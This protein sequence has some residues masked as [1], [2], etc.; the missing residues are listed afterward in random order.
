MADGHLAAPSDADISVFTSTDVDH[1]RAVLNRF[2]YPIS[3]GVTGAG[4][5]FELNLKV[6]QLGPLTVGQLRFGAGVS[7]VAP[8]LDAYHVT[9]PRTGSCLTRHA[10][11]EVEANPDRAAVFGP[12]GRVFTL[13]EPLSSELDLKIAQ[14]ELEHELERMLDHTVQGP[15]DLG[16]DLDLASG[17]GQSWRRLTVLLADELE[18][19]ATLIRKPLIAEHLRRSLIDGLLL[20]APHRYQA[21]L[22]A[23]PPAAPPRSIRKAVDAIHDEPDRAF[24]VT[25]LAGVAGIS[26]RSLQEGFR[27]YLD[28]TPMSYLQ[29]VR[30]DR[31]RDTLRAADPTMLTVASVAHRWGFAHLGRFASSYRSRFGETPSETLRHAYSPGSPRLG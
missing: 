11:R 31:A 30:L 25:D 4:T 20:L 17:V 12:A 9:L 16:A 14:P 22:A 19:P 23:P 5:G 6:I 1:A 26:V 27:R 15:L 28:C 29:Q 7:L 2:Y 18:D 10:G 24:G 8:E 3:V 21:E 13:H